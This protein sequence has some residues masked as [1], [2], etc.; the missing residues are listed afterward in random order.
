ME[1]MIGSARIN[2]NGKVS[3]GKAGDQTGKEVSIQPFYQHTKG[4]ICLRPK[5]ANLANGLAQSMTDMC[6]NDNIGYCQDHR[7]GIITNLKI[8]GK[9]AKIKQKTET[10]CSTGVRA[11]CIENGFDPGN[12][13]TLNEVCTLSDTG[14][15]EKPF[16]V[17]SAS[18]LCN[19]DI[20]VTKT[21]GHTAI[22]VSGNPRATKSPITSHYKKY[23][24]TSQKIDE[25]FKSIGVPAKYRGSFV[26]RKAIANAN[27]IK[28]YGGTMEQ[29]LNLISLA[30]HGK[31][32]KIK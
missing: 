32:K 30:K 18:Q 14:K 31:L 25:V 16:D 29:N 12:F 22:V 8:Y 27:G 19:G 7:S 26:N 3:G 13:T 1:I 21:K 24:G 17:T 23:T 28:S 10:D 2:E 20:I 4:W 15:F 5:T 9:I 11:C 6:K